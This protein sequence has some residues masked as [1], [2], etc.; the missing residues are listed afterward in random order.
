MSCTFLAEKPAP[1]A[2]MLQ[3]DLEFP[4]LRHTFSWCLLVPLVCLCTTPGLKSS[5]PQK[6]KCVLV[7]LLCH[8]ITM[9][10]AH[11]QMC[12]LKLVTLNH[13][14][15]YACSQARGR[16]AQGT[17]EE[18]QLPEQQLTEATGWRNP[19]CLFFRATPSYTSLFFRAAQSYTSLFFRAAQ[20]CAYS[21]CLFFCCWQHQPSFLVA[22]GHR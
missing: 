15:C 2:S 5:L 20:F 17:E 3:A 1:L 16:R 21:P 7:S 12:R 19:P 22:S 10:D 13:V 9:E 11:C 4:N 14:A 8:D 18:E 6:H